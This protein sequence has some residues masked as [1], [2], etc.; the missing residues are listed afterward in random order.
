[1]VFLSDIHGGDKSEGGWQISGAKD[2]K[3]TEVLVE[4]GSELRAGF[5][6]FRSVRGVLCSFWTMGG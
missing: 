3:V 4:T 2:P 1:M 5:D 6:A